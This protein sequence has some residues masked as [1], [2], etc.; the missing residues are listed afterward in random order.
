ME[1]LAKSSP[2]V[3]LLRLSGLEQIVR[4]HGPQSAQYRTACSTL[5]KFL[6]AVLTST[7][8]STTILIAVPPKPVH[9]RLGKRTSFSLLAPFQT[10][11]S[12]FVSRSLLDRRSEIFGDASKSMPIISSTRQ[13]YTNASECESSTN[14]CNGHG[15]CVSGQKTSG[16]T[17]F[18]CKC[19]QAKDTKGKVVGWSGEMCQKQDVSRYVFIYIYIFGF[20]AI[21]HAQTVS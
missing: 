5:K 6:E 7:I 21:T 13:C 8:D 2:Q 4:Q 20:E 16:G 1:S 15:T 17:C 3:S 18:V 11:E 14:T 10:T 9:T 12:S 19:G